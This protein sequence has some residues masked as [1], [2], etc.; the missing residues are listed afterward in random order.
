M[1]Y[2][3]INVADLV[4]KVCVVLFAFRYD[5]SFGSPACNPSELFLPKAIYPSTTSNE[6]GGEDRTF[7]S[8]DGTHGDIFVD[9][10][11]HCTNLSLCIHGDLFLNLWRT[12]E[13]L[14]DGS[15]QPQVI[16]TPDEGGT[17]SLNTIWYFSASDANLDPTPNASSPH[18]DHDGGISSFLPLTCINRC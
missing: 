2:L 13:L 6:L 12:L 9:I 11:I 15:V 10:E 18:F 4:P 1:S 5:A 16:A 7:N 17:T 8:S 14:F 3:L